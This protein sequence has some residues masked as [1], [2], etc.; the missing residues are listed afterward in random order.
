MY[1]GKRIIDQIMT[2][3]PRIIS[4]SAFN[5]YG[6]NSTAHTLLANIPLGTSK[7]NSVSGADN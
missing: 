6:T 7:D 1:G 5:L 2:K 4:P 3:T